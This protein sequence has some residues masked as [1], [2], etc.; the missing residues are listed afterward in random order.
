[1]I[2]LA[3]PHDIPLFRPFVPRSRLPCLLPNS[4]L[5]ITGGIIWAITSTFLMVITICNDLP[6]LPLSS[7][8]DAFPWP[9]SLLHTRLHMVETQSR[10]EVEFP[11]DPGIHGTIPAMG[12]NG[13]QFVPAWHNSEG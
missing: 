8:V 7:C 13:L 2:V 9:S 1:M 11:G 10:Y 12:V 6:H 4:I 5:T 3:S